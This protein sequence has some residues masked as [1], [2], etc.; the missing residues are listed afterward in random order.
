[1]LFAGRGRREGHQEARRLALDD[2]QEALVREHRVA[3]IVGRAEPVALDPPALRRP[4]G[5]FR[6]RRMESAPLTVRTSVGERSD[7]GAPM[8]PDDAGSRKRR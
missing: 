4:D 1:M 5:P 6:V 7:P 2:V 8:R 3:A